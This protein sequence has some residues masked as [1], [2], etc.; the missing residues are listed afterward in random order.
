MN[1]IRASDDGRDLSH[2]IGVL[3][4]PDVIG[5]HVAVDADRGIARAQ[6]PDDIGAIG[7]ERIGVEDDLVEASDARDRRCVEATVRA[8]ERAPVTEDRAVQAEAGMA[9]VR[10]RGGGDHE[11]EEDE[12]GEDQTGQADATMIRTHGTHSSGGTVSIRGFAFVASDQQGPCP[13]G[14]ECVTVGTS[15]GVRSAMR[16]TRMDD[17]AIRAHIP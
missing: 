1:A 10:V 4:L 8:D 13:V 6:R 2:R 15:L 17:E 7:G 9:G 11:T 14:G 12:G 5:E 16:T 3:R